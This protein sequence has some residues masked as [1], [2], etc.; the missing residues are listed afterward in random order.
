MGGGNVSSPCV[1]VWGVEEQKAGRGEETD[2][3]QGAKAAQKRERNAKNSGATAKSQLKLNE[4]ALN[5]QCE[6]CK[7]TFLSTTRENA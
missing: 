1:C 2:M 4:K 7:A 5:I 3:Q 6:V